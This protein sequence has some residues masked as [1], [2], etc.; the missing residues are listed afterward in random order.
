MDSSAATLP[1]PPPIVEARNLAPGQWGMAAFLLSEVAFFS[2]LI[3]TYVT[4][5]GEDT[6]GPKPNEVLE[7]RLAILNTICLLASS[8][9]IHGPQSALSQG[10]LPTFRSLWTLTI[11]LGAAF[12]CGT[13]YEWRQLIFVD[14]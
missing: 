2:T 1:V 12:L 9:T 4:F 5:M 8:V 14:H 11:L 3:V 13:A 6:V 10:R 7:L